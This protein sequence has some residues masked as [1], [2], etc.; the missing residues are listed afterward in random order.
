[1]AAVTPAEF[2]GR[3]R[4]EKQKLTLDLSRCGN[5]WCGVEVTKGTA[6]ARTVLRL[7]SGEQGRDPAGFSGRLQLAPE[8]E[9]YGVRTILQARGGSMVLVITGH[10]GGSFQFARRTFD[11]QAEF[12]R[13]DDAVCRPDAKIS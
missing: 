1:M 7:D 11:F 12:V 9:S 6:C 4:S 8:S 2:G 13:I 5:G 3:W 10:T